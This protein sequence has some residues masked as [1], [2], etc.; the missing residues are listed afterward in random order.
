M[1]AGRVI[2]TAVTAAT[3]TVIAPA[4]TATRPDRFRAVAGRASAGV[5]RTGRL[6]GGCGSAAGGRTTGSTRSGG[7]S[8]EYFASRPR[9]N[10]ARI[11]ASESPGSPGRSKWRSATDSSSTDE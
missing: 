11:A 8:P 4:A 3:A 1:S 5:L 10:A 2:T 6:G 7:G 9:L